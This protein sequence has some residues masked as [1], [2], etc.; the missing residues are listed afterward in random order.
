[1]VKVKAFVTKYAYWLFLCGLVALIAGAC[2][3]DLSWVVLVYIAGCAVLLTPEQLVATFMFTWCFDGLPCFTGSPLNGFL[4]YYLLLLLAGHYFYTYL[5]ERRGRVNGRLL[6]VTSVFCLYVVLR[7][8]PL[9]AGIVYPIY[10]FGL[11]VLVYEQREKLAFTNLLKVLAVGL[12]VSGVLGLLYYVSPYLKN[13]FLILPAEYGS[14][15]PYAHDYYR[16]QGLTRWCTQYAGLAT[17]VVGGLL[18]AKYQKRLNDYWFYGLFVP[19]FIFAYQTLTRTFLLCALVALIIFAVAV[20]W[21]DRRQAWRTLVPLAGILVAVAVIFFTATMGNFER[22]FHDNAMEG[23][24]LEVSKITDEDWAAI[25]E[26]DGS[27]Y[28][29][30]GRRVLWS[31]YASD[32]VSSVTNLLWGQG[33]THVLF[34]AS[35]PHNW[36]LYFVWKYG[37]VGLVLFGAMFALM[38]NWR[39]WRTKRFWVRLAP[40]LILVVP[41]LLHGVFDDNGYWAPMS[42][43]LLILWCSEQPRLVV[44][45]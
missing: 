27:Y 22:I 2:F 1:M 29:I 15:E 34:S 19:V 37:L 33:V 26:G 38:I 12:I 3:T 45:A 16:F 4:W 23:A 30:L 28:D 13:L 44:S 6:L 39:Q 18:L 10:T 11:F 17:I 9:N 36:Y 5:V 41:I 42:I 24:P 43:I 40:C 21:R 25:K 31:F 20:C 14:M 32:W 7:S 35:T 8:F